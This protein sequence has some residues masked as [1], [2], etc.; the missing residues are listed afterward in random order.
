MRLHV[1]RLG[2]SSELPG[3]VVVH[4]ALICDLTAPRHGMGL[5]DALP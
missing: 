4:V 1:H 2:S 3:A 5:D